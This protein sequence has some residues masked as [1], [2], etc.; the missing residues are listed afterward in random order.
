VP[1][2]TTTNEPGGEH[3]A[4]DRSP[5]G[6]LRWALGPAVDPVPATMAAYATAVRIVLGLLWLWNVNWKVPPDFG[7]TNEVGL[8]KFTEFAVTHPVFPPYA[9]LTEHLILPNLSVF[10]WLVILSETTLAVLLLSG[11]WVRLAALL[12]IAQSVAIALSV[13]FAPHEWAWAY[14]L[15]I[16]AHLALLS[17]S[18]GRYLAVDAV[19]AGLSDGRTVARVAGGVAVVAGLYSTIRGLG[20]PLAANGPQIGTSSWE[21][22]LGSFNV[23]G[24]VVLLVVGVSLVAAE[25]LGATAAWVSVAVALAAAVLMRIQ[26]G[27]EGR[28][29]GGGGT[30]AALLITLALVAFTRARALGERR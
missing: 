22:G 18:P 27:F 15:M 29:L 26:A 17:S 3:T 20:D 13:A 9:W 8:Y 2:P 6:L 28:L 5:R 30:S 16:A 10:G 11:A 14:L 7:R 21:V 4:T 1:D 12:G 25:R 23:L 24:G 19:R